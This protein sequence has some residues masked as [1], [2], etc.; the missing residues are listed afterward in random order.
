M[1]QIIEKQKEMS[2]AARSRAI[3]N[4]DIKQWVIKH[5]VVFLS[6]C[7]RNSQAFKPT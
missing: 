6:S 7:S 4:F 1:M 3:D 5:K 2:Q